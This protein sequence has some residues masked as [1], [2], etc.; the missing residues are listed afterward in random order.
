MIFMPHSDTPIKVPKKFRII[1]HR[2]ASGYAPENTMAAFHL[3]EKMGA[4]E[5]EFDVQFSSDQKLMICHDP[6]LSRYEHPGKH[7]SSLTCKEMQELDMGSWFGVPQYAGEKTPTLDEVF[8]TF[9]DRFIYHVEI[10]TPAP[11]LSAAILDCIAEHN[12]TDRTFVTSFHFDALQ[13]CI[14]LG[15]RANNVAFGWLVRENAFN[16]DNIKR[17]ADAGF[18][19]FCPLASEVTKDRVTEAHK[20]LSEV[21]A[22]GVK[23]KT[24]M[25]RVIETGCDGLTIN[26][27]DWLLQ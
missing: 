22:H 18:S 13:E 20:H 21:R 27:P 7:V 17:A 14:A 9:R 15:N 16:I 2:G 24:D 3:A 19:Q 12:I 26:W 25:I 6:E 8:S 5:I 23:S 4:T 1:A 10:K 11:G